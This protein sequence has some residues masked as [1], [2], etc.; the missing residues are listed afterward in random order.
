MAAPPRL[1]DGIVLRL[2]PVGEADLIV[3]MLTPERGRVDAYARSARSSLKRFGGRLELFLDGQAALRDGRGRLP[4]LLTFERR[5]ELLGGV[6][7]YPRLALASLAAEL[8]L[9][10]AQPEHPDVALERWLR[11]AL[12]AVRAFPA[13]ALAE[14]RLG[15]EFGWLDALGTLPTIDVCADCGGSVDAG[16]AWVTPH[17]GARC[18]SCSPARAAHLRAEDVATL[19]AAIAGGLQPGQRLSPSAA[20]LLADRSAGLLAEHLSRPPRSAEALAALARP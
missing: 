9:C 3:S 4:T 5:G 15:L 10:A 14:A 7:D 18:L 11:G 16:L 6:V 20:R 19:R 17:D 2:Q 8:A 1:L 13:G 12:V